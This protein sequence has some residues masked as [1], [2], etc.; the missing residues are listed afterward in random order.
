MRDDGAGAAAELVTPRLLESEASRV[1][2][3]ERFSHY[4]GKVLDPPL[5]F[6]FATAACRTGFCEAEFRAVAN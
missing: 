3:L 5:C 1:Q 6:S 2:E 4:V